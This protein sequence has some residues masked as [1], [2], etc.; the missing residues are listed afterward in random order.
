MTERIAI[1]SMAGRF[2]GAGA[3][4]GRFWENVAGAA[5]CSREVPPGRWALP[6][7]RC[8]DPRVANP[9]TVY[10]TR[11]YYLDPF[12]PDLTA[13]DLDAGMV[14]DL[15]PLFHLVLDAGNRAWRGARTD[16]VDRARVGVVLGNICL[17]TDRANDLC[18]EVL[19]G[20]LGLPPQEPT[21]PLNR[22]V[23]GL[24]AGVL[25]KALG[26]GGGSFTLDAACA[27]SLY[28]L[29]LAADEL[30]AGRADAML[31]GGCSRPDCQYTQM[32]FAQLRALA[33]SGRCAPFD[34]RADGLVVGEGAG[35]FVLKRLTDAIKHGDAILGVIAG[36][37]LSND[38]H[39]NL[40]APAKEG[41]LR[42]MRAAYSRAGWKP[43]DVDLIECHATGT[44]V[45]DAVE[46][47]S[48]R[49]LWGDSGWTAGQCTIG[50]VKSTVGHL[51]TGA[52]GAALTKV[53]LAMKAETLPPQANFATPA[54]GLRY[55]DGPF[56]VLQK[57]ERWNRRTSLEP[58]RAAVS[59]FG[60]GGVNAH[61][62]IEEWTGIPL[63]PAAARK[64]TAKP[65]K[66]V[67]AQSKAA[68]RHPGAARATEPV[69]V[70][71][72]AA[73]VGP[74]ADARAIQEHLLSGDAVRPR[75]KKNGWG[76]ASEPC[77]A[78][79]YIE[80]LKLPIDRFRIPPKEL[81]ETLPQQ[82]LM[83]QV[84]ASALDDAPT[85]AKHPSED[86]PTTGVFIGLGL[87]PNTTNFHLRWL[88]HGERLPEPSVN[89]RDSSPSRSGDRALLP[90][91]TTAEVRPPLGRHLPA[92]HRRTA[93]WARSA[94]SRRAASRGRSTSAVR[95]TRFAAKKAPRREPSNS[96]CGHFSRTSSTARWSAGWTSRATRG[97]YFPP[98]CGSPVKA[99]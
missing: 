51:L 68:S 50:S 75:T 76:L 15:D 73:H 11:G 33:P 23:A 81:E 21:H 37:G 90:G 54:A 52:G 72:L 84:A 66:L 12:D 61:L 43:Q 74:W 80:E 8:T 10:S 1:V 4:L 77:P 59:G 63:K 47:D 89:P 13:L 79:F 17:P 28:A 39:G 64:P 57:P 56:R 60:F 22:Y 93:R 2:P 32:G 34:A 19:G 44:P 69:A 3:D 6:P 5:D 48:L 53:L 16:Q 91:L 92:A 87:D 97:W 94:A 42:A 25:A 31:A 78:G 46:F 38:M 7:D 86:H 58:R 45:G 70:V 9:D 14:G 96:V 62:L 55:A 40:L 27:S 85:S 82:L 35:V 30:I 41:Q 67:T 20:K 65:P 18:R 24:P 49:E 29:K 98:A 71:G 88:C 83:L 36:V 99:P 26:L 95:A